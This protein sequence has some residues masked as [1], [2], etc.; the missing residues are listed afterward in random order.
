MD[1]KKVEAN[2]RMNGR[3]DKCSTI[4]WKHKMEAEGCHWP[5]VH[6]EPYKKSV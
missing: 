2:G 6:Q 1:P 3:S 5:L 4:K